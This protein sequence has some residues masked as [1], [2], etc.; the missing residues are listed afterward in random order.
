MYY[1]YIYIYERIY[2]SVS[3]ELGESS[4]SVYEFYI[5][6]VCVSYEC[7]RFAFFVF[8]F[9]HDSNSLGGQLSRY[10]VSGKL[11]EINM[12]GAA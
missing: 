4:I 10:I 11:P 2:Y 3:I 5:L 9:I 6:N 1:I 7:G 12:E 8:A